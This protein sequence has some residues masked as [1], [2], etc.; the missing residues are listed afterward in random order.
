MREPSNAELRTYLPRDVGPGSWAL[1]ACQTIAHDHVENCAQ[2]GESP[3]GSGLSKA[4]RLAA[5]QFRVRP[6]RVDGK[7]MV[8]AWV[9]IRI[10][11]NGTAARRPEPAASGR[12][13]PN[14]PVYDLWPGALTQMHRP[15]A[16]GPSP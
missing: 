9:R 14:R 4:M 6:P 3:R 7:P 1:I 11:F 8:G 13:V 16:R 5:W 15:H 12:A 10:D 2:L